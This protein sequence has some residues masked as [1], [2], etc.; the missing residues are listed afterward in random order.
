M[1]E[2]RLLAVSDDKATL[3]LLGRICRKRGFDLT[4]ADDTDVLRKH[5]AKGTTDLVVLDLH[6][7]GKLSAT[8]FVKQ[9]EVSF[10]DFLA[11][12]FGQ[13]YGVGRTLAPMVVDD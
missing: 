8:G 4:Q 12:R 13:H 9:E 3:A 5:V 11:N 2:T 1:G 10:E 6:A 7:T